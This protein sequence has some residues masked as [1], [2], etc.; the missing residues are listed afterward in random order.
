MTSQSELLVDWKC[1][2]QLPNN[3]CSTSSALISF[4]FTHLQTL[5]YY[6]EVAIHILVCGSVLGKNYNP[7]TQLLDQVLFSHQVYGMCYLST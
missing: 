4:S 5:C 7:V 1:V 2:S 3:L 6:Y